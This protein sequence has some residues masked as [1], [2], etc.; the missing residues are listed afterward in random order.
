MSG[1][2]RR[3]ASVPPPP[4]APTV[5]APVLPRGNSQIGGPPPPP[6]TSLAIVSAAS[7]PPPPV[8]HHVHTASLPAAVLNPPKAMSPHPMT[9]PGTAASAIA[10]APPAP[11]KGQIIFIVALNKN[12][13]L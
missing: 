8:P 9:I 12:Y 3:G 13:E 10:A 6:A 5:T 2:L 11:R 4:P 1:T 7:L